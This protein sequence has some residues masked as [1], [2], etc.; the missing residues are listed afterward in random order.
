MKAKNLKTIS[1]GKYEVKNKCIYKGKKKIC[2]FYIKKLTMNYHLKR[3]VSFTITLVS[4]SANPDKE[5]KRAKKIERKATIPM[6]CMNNPSGWLYY[7]FDPE[8]FYTFS[9][10]DEFDRTIN[11]IIDMMKSNGKC[12]RKKAVM[13]WRIALSV[14]KTLKIKRR[15]TFG[16]F[17]DPSTKV[18]YVGA[19]KPDDYIREYSEFADTEISSLLFSYMLLSLLGSFDLLRENTRPDFVIV[20]TGGSEFTRRKTALFFTNLFNRNLAFGKNDYYMTHIMSSDSFAEIRFKTEFAKDCVLIA[21]EPDKKHLNYLIKDIYGIRA[22]DEKHPVRSMCLITTEKFEYTDRNVINIHLPQ[23]Y[24][25][26]KLDEYFSLT[27]PVIIKGNGTADSMFYDIDASL[28]VECKEDELM[29]SIVYYIDTLTK[30]LVTNTNYVNEKF[31]EYKA[32][33]YALDYAENSQNDVEEA[34]TLLS[35]AYWLYMNEYHESQ[36]SATEEDIRK[37]VCRI[38]ETAKTLF[39]TKGTSKAIDFENAKKI[40]IAID[41]FFE[42][43][44]YQT[45]LAKLGTQEVCDDVRMWYDEEYLYIRTENIREFLQLGS[46]KTAFS[47]KIKVALAEKGLIKKYIKSDGKPEYSVHIQK[48]LREPITDDT[49]KGKAEANGQNETDQKKKDKSANNTANKTPK[50]YIAFDRKKCQQYHLFDHV[51]KAILLKQNRIVV[52]KYVKNN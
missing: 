28:S 44:M 17:N 8:Y 31:S 47:L 34:A 23:E 16:D 15:I 25:F 10:K 6:C 26:E 2:N 35:F 5:D 39:L 40:C 1:K 21:F 4:K 24:N 22:I 52:K 32:G 50:R 14:D 3:V 37:A 19:N 36:D 51:E 48:N 41:S 27:K 13:G 30:K 46:I 33:N 38:Y 18:Y 49:N 43:K 7:E 42:K 9:G 20:L 12:R 45:K 29:N 11:E